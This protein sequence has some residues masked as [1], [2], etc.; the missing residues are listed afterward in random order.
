M[1]F[2]LNFCLY[3]IFNACSLL[4]SADSILGVWC[5]LNRW[6]FNFSY[7][8]QAGL[9]GAFSIWCISCSITLSRP[10]LSLSLVFPSMYSENILI[11]K[12]HI[13]RIL[14]SV[15]YLV[16][17]WFLVSRPRLSLL[18]LTF[19][20]QNLAGIHLNIDIPKWLHILHLDRLNSYAG[21]WQS[22]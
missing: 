14:E 17:T 3:L 20:L 18:N 15:P 5:T 9:F 10:P 11:S 21:K 16:I 1:F 4:F 12:W 8:Q 19:K 6:G 13:W 22:F 7:Y 2:F